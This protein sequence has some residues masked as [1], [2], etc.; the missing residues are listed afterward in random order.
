MPASVVDNL[1][2]RIAVS[3]SLAISEIFVGDA[4]LIDKMLGAF[5]S[6]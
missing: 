3:R 6:G 5:A 4:T 2:R 1:V